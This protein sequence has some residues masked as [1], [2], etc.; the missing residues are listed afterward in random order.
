M[1]VGIFG[2][3]GT[4]QAASWSEGQNKRPELAGLVWVAFL[5]FPRFLFMFLVGLIGLWLGWF[6]CFDVNS[7]L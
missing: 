2:A 6:S 1:A 7:H 3:L 4:A 5:E